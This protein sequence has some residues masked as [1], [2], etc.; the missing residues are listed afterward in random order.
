MHLCYILYNL[1]N[2]KTYNGY[3]VNLKR[4]IRQHNSEIKGGARATT[5]DSRREGPDYWH[6]LTVI[7]CIDNDW[8][9]NRALSLEW[10]IRYPRARR[11]PRGREF[12]GP[13]GRIRGLSLALSHTKFVN[14]KFKVSVCP[15]YYEVGKNMLASCTNVEVFKLDQSTSSMDEADTTSLI[16]STGD[17]QLSSPCVFI[18]SS[19]PM[20]TPSPNSIIL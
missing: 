2:A 16:D 9:K 11:G 12:S 15:E 8:S 18:P 1:S 20:P 5:C 19:D 7:E 14:N 10:H 4:R 17:E 3:T 6:F 13:I